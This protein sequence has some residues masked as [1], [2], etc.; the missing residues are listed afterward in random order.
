M[1]S[2]FHKAQGDAQSARILAF[3]AASLARI[4]SAVGTGRFVY[5]AAV[6]HRSRIALRRT[7]TE[8]SLELARI[9]R[10]VERR[11]AVL[12]EAEGLSG[13]TPA[14]ANALLILFQNKEPLTARQVAAEMSVSEVTVGRFVRAL[15]D[16]GWIVRRPDPKDGRA[17]ALSP[18]RKAYRAFPRLLRVS[19]ALL[20]Q[21]F[22]GLSRAELAGLRKGLQALQRNLSDEA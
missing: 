9:S 11:L 2:I 15:A 4:S 17:I 12:L 18:S 5:S 22:T 21:T 8:I 10:A 20:E 1:L 16:A 6:N 19:N 3:E 14:Q 7:Q 13:I